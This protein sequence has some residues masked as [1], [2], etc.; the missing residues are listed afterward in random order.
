MLHEEGLM[1]TVSDVGALLN[2]VGDGIRN[3]RTI[4]DATRDGYAYL[5]AHHSGAQADLASLLVEMGKLTE[6]LADAA[7][8]I[9]GFA[10]TVSG[11]DV[12][13]QPRAFNDLVVDRQA[14]FARFDAQLE[15]TRSHCSVIGN[16]AWRLGE[17]ARKKGLPNLFGLVKAGTKR[18]EEMSRQ[19]QE[20]YG[21][22]AELLSQFKNMAMAVKLALGDVQAAL[23]PPGQMDPG[24]VPAAAKLL[25][26][27]STRFLAIQVRADDAKRE[28][29]SLVNDLRFPHLVAARLG[30]A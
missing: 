3:V 10:F 4:V 25:G 16:H 15:V 24:N 29:N 13:R 30:T 7:S 17:E 5:Q 2:L 9:T 21:N 6:Y 20:V 14:V 23:G 27:Y 11:S 8:I 26:E 19:V 1:S 18:A 12:A 22:D 28:L